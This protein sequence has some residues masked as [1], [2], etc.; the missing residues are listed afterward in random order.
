VQ[1]F[2][3]DTPGTCPVDKTPLVPITASLYFT[4]ASDPHVRELTPGRCPD[5]SARIKGFE[6]RPHG[7]HNPRHGGT[8]FMAT[9]QWHHLEGTI[10]PPG[11]FRLYFYDDMTRPLRATGFS[12]H[13]TRVDGN[14]REREPLL[15]LGPGS[16]K[17]GSALEIPILGLEFP[18]DV[19]LRVKFKPDDKDHVFDFSF[20]TYSKEP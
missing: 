10:V 7:D 6:R 5:G 16:V 14:G 18:Q 17:D 3:R 20:A 11:V 1:L 13:I 12:A 4:C 9:D 2:I 8:L 19:K 15:T